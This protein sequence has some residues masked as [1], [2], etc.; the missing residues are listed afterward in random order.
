[1]KYVILSPTDERRIDFP[2]FG[3]ERAG[4]ND[5]VEESLPLPPPP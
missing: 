5:G 1:M 3:D 4:L 2:P